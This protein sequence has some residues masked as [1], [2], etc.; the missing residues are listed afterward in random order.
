MDMKKTKYIGVYEVVSKKRIFQ[1]KPDVCYYYSYKINR[2]KVWKKV[3]WK[4]EG[5]SAAFANQERIITIQ[6]IKHGK[7]I[8]KISMS[9]EQAFFIYDRDFLS[10]YIKRPDDDRYRFKKYILPY[11]GKMEISEITA[12]DI[13]IFYTRLLNKKLSASSIRLIIGNIR[14][15]YKKFIEW[16]KLTENPVKIK[17][18]VKDVYRTRFL[19]KGEAKNLLDMLQIRSPIWHDISFISL[20]TG[21]RLTEVL[22]LEKQD[23]SF[24][25]NT[26]HIRDSKT[27]SRTIYAINN[28]M[29]II[30]KRMPDSATGRIFTKRNGEPL[31]DSFTAKI[32][33]EC[34]NQCGLN[35]HGIDRR[36]RVCFHTLRH[37]FC[38]WLAMSGEPLYIIAEIVGH[39]SMEM[40]KKYSHLCPTSAKKAVKTLE[41]LI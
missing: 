31:P 18:K 28:V 10:I 16:E 15:L 30:K 20:Y 40:T 11:F 37:T 33:R 27:G 29:E 13:N 17:H 4:S 1:S 24:E 14:R 8:T 34:V 32:F 7:V 36:N 35:P 38:S 23:I 26:I 41:N 2:K 9:F 19:T 21:M 6:K 22:H 39:S 25:T 5:F 12:N 3:G